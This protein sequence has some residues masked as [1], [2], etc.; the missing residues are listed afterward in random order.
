M[1]TPTKKY[2]G[3]VLLGSKDTYGPKVSKLIDNFKGIIRHNL[4]CPGPD[5]VSKQVTYVVG[6]TN[7]GIY[8]VIPLRLYKKL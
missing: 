4:I 5:H 3:Y 8:I 1:P 7:I 6:V 2:D